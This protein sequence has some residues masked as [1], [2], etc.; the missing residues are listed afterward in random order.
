MVG[1]SGS[2]GERSLPNKASGRA[3]PALI[4]ERLA[5]IEETC[6]WELLPR[7]AVKPVLPVRL[8]IWSGQRAN[9]TRRAGLGFDD[10]RHLHY[11][12]DDR[13]ERAH[14]DIDR[15]GRRKRVDGGD[16]ASRIGVLPEGRFE[17][18]RWGSGG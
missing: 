10:H 5:E 16:G 17:G 2:A 3:L 12:L 8:V 15:A 13:T 4:W 9:Q 6:T 7:K 18:G 14:D 11:R 1:T